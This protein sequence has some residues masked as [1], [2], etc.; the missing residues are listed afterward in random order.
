MQKHAH[1]F[2]RNGACPNWNGQTSTRIP[3]YEKSH[4]WNCNNFHANQ[5]KIWSYFWIWIKFPFESSDDFPVSFQLTKFDIFLQ[6]INE[7]GKN[8]KNENQIFC[9]YETSPAF[10]GNICFLSS[11]FE[12]RQTQQQKKLGSPENS[13]W[14]FLIC[15]NLWLKERVGWL[16]KQEQVSLCNKIFSIKLFFIKANISGMWMREPRAQCI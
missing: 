6:I 16:K 10:D 7:M 12:W 15:S 1:Y 2:H 14:N 8:K 3:R 9:R 11:I 13:Q 5:V 4:E